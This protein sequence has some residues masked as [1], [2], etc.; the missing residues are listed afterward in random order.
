MKYGA[1]VVLA[2][3]AAIATYSATAWSAAPP[4]P[5]EQKLQR[6]INTLK[7]Q[8]SKLQKD[9]KTLK[10]NV[11]D[12][13]GGISLALVLNACTNAVTADAFQGTWQV[14]DQLS[15]ATQAGKTYFG[16]QTAIS[17]ALSGLTAPA[18]QAVQVVRSQALPPT[19]AQLDALL[20]VLRSAQ[21]KNGYRLNHG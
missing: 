15:T 10:A 21:L 6:Q 9:D 17:D 8:V 19:S 13:I 5:T 2:L 20:G 7:T 4:T 11:N 14:I 18:C 12:L 16:P 3:V 1:F